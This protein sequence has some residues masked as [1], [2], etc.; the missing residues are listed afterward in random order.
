MVTRAR[1]GIHKPK[2]PY[3][4]LSECK[5]YA[6]RASNAISSSTFYSKEP[7]TVSEAL[8]S[9]VWKAAMDAE[10]RALQ[11]NKTWVLIPP[12]QNQKIVDSKWVFKIKYQTDGSI[13]KHK[14]RLVAK[15]FQQVPGVDFGETFSPVVKATTVR[16][17]LTLAVT[18]GWPVRQ[19]DV[20][21]TFLNGYLQE[22]V[23]MRQPEGFEDAQRPTHVCR[24]VKALYG[25][26]QAPRAWFDRLRDTLL[27]WGFKN[28]KS[29]VS[30]FFLRTATLTVFVLIYVDDILVTGYNS[31]YLSDFIKRLNSIFAL[32]DLGP[33]SYFLGIEAC[34]D[35]SG[36]YLSQEKYI[37]DILD[38]LK[39][40][41][42]APVDTPMVTGRKF[43]AKD[44]TLMKDPYLYR[45]AI[46][47]LQY[48]TTTRP[49]ISFVVNKLSQFL[50]SP[51]DVHYSG[52]KRILRYLQGT[53]HI[54]LHIRPA[55]SLKLVA[56]TDADWATDLDDRKS[57]GG[58]CTYLGNT[59]LSWASRIQRVFSRSST[60]SEYRALAD[61]AAEVRWI[62]SLLT[63][64]GLKL[65]QPAMI[66]CDNL[67]A[68][69]LAA[70]PVQHA[71]SKH[72]EIDVHFVRDMILSNEV[73]VHYVPSS[74]QVADCFTK[75]LSQ[76][77]FEKNRSK[78]GLVE[79]PSSLKGRARA[80]D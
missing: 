55:S 79:I 8:S 29:D 51:I 70:N 40:S 77:Q 75:A 42:C 26:K 41:N 48:L 37:A 33:L 20:N 43:T 35:S 76:S 31:Q 46:G 36:M 22:V 52:V 71:R 50:S 17:I 54:G 66:W 11:Q 61:S 9:S 57:V 67:S 45:R 39:M 69:A 5:D 60:E 24:L 73:D 28:S 53:K 78:L 23:L 12:S 27:R 62:T 19:L 21:N 64:L 7:S 4:G 65:S 18:F 25:L 56:Y 30:L 1:D 80:E 14:A 3:I 49:D 72:I 10:F 13:L 44:G 15:G 16:T 47:S 38:K 74:L 63:E 34:R 58:M 68:K 2:I 6:S 59:L 32:K